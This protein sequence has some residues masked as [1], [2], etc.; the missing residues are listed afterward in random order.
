MRRERLVLLGRFVL[1]LL[2]SPLVGWMLVRAWQPGTVLWEATWSFADLF[3]VGISD[4]NDLMMSVAL[5]VYFGILGLFTVDWRKRIQGVLILIGTLVGLAV[6]AIND[7]LIPNIAANV[8]NVGGFVVGLAL[9][10]VLERK[11]LLDLV[12][13]GDLQRSEFDYVVTLL[14]VFLAVVLLGGYAQGIAYG[15]ASP[16]LDTGA[17][18]A[19][20]YL[21]VQFIS[22]TADVS[23]A[24]VGPRES[25]KSTTMLGLYYTFMERTDNV[26]AP[27]DPME[28]LIRLASEMDQGQDFP[29]PN[30]EDFEIV[31]FNHEIR[32][33]FPKQ[34]RV[35]S[36]EHPGEA[37]SDLADRVDQ[38]TSLVG[39]AILFLQDIRTLLLPGYSRSDEE[40]F[41]YETP[42]SEIGIILIDV[43]GILFGDTDPEIGN[44]QTVGRRIRENG[45]D[46]IVVATKCDLLLED[47]GDNDQEFYSW[48]ID[49]LT[50]TVNERLTKENAVE[51]LLNNVQS[52]TIYPLYF[53]MTETEDETLVPD[54]DEADNLQ[55]V[56]HE[57]LAEEIEKRV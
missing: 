8:F 2:L 38:G 23:T 9:V 31:G 29:I 21:L 36:W 11:A 30:T 53:R 25:G 55:P 44:L 50:E 42:Q 47:M 18:A 13:E 27:T 19:T 33:Y 15:Y 26:T 17:T 45:G 1:I 40:R 14:F 48:A 39:E 28:E 6:L 24:F 56:G 35:S 12:E 41:L 20:L 7:I 43:E 34:I 46:V 49:E 10:V 16:L 22:Y 37:L 57:Q 52:D 4:P 5:G 51:G 54:L 3:D 32:G